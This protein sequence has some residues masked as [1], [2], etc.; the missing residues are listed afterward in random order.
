MKPLVIKLADYYSVE[1]FEAG[2][3]ILASGERLDRF[4]VIVKGSAKDVERG[5]FFKK[6]DVLLLEAL[7]YSK[8]ARGPIVALSET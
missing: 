6:K 3:T 7:R 8:K 2:A 4:M 5:Q 1:K